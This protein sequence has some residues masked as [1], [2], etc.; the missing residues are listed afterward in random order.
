MYN[1]LSD[2]NLVY[3]EKAH[4]KMSANYL[5]VFFYLLHRA[6]FDRKLSLFNLTLSN[7]L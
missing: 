7:A 6:H 3:T 2:V 1:V 4:Q 5:L